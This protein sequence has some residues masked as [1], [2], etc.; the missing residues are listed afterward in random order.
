MTA[1]ALLQTKPSQFEPY[2]G[3]QN[4]FSLSQRTVFLSL[5]QRFASTSPNLGPEVCLLSLPSPFLV[6]FEP[7]NLAWN[8]NGNGSSSSVVLVFPL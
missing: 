4:D 8:P 7:K 1:F 5:S 6:A 2:R 3:A